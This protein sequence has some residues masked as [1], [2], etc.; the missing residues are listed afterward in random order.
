MR[1]KMWI[2]PK[3]KNLPTKSD[4]KSPQSNHTTAVAFDQNMVNFYLTRGKT[5]VED[6]KCAGL[7]NKFLISP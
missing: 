1:D 3:T 2:I 7:E 6:G 5:K 4:P